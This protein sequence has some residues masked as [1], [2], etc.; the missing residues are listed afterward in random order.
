MAETN[1]TFN[2][3]IQIINYIHTTPFHPSV[4]SIL[5]R[6]IDI[7]GAII[8]LTITA[9]IIA[10]IAIT[11]KI[12]NPGPI[13]DSQIRCGL[14]G[15]LF[16]IWMFRSRVI[17]TDQ[18]KHL[19]KNQAKNYIFVSAEEPRIMP[20]GRFM[21]RTSLD[22]L[23]Q[24]WNVLMGDMSLV[25]PVP[26]TPDQVTHYT[27]HDWKRLQVRP[28]MTG[29]LQVSNLSSITDFETIVSLDLQYQKNW[30]VL[31]DIQIILKTIYVVFKPL[32]QY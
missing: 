9:I 5:K 15:E 21:R 13:F 12:T 11:I 27:L 2:Q 32:P 22:V 4:E 23:P 30:S 19:D 24:F 16:R 29:L 26:S 6:F 25:G 7:I 1:Q 17:D 28:G 31:L 14:K 8:G 20:I 3:A 10:P 18:I